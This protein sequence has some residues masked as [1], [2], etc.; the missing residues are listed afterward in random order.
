[1]R[2]EERY[3]EHEKIMVTLFAL[4]IALSIAGCFFY[5]FMVRGFE[6]GIKWFDHRS[7][8]KDRPPQASP[9]SKKKKN[10]PPTN[11][12]HPAKQQA[13]VEEEEEWPEVITL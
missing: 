7:T 3:T 12:K 6:Q 13:V 9:V 2:A 5:R 8:R 1:M 4:I 11:G 10:T